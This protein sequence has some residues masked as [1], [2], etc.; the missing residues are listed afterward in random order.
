MSKWVRYQHKGQVGFGTLSDGRIEEH[1]G[2]MFAGAVATG[3]TV[4]LDEVELLTPSVPSKMVALCNNFH[5]LVTKLGMATPSEP[6]YFLK[7]NNS[8]HPHGKPIRRPAWY[9]GKVIFEG[10]LGLVIGRTCKEVAVEHALDYLFGCTCINDV[11]SIDLLNKDPSFTHWTRA[12]APDTFG[13]FGPCIATV[14][15]PSALVVKSSL[16][17]TERQ[18]YPISN[19]VFSAAQLISSI[20]HDMTLNPGD[21]VA[22]G[23]SVGVGSMKPG[24]RI[25]ISIEGIGSLINTFE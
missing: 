11:T 3:Q 8:F 20:S 10:E 17:D 22:C 13:V 18:N 2:D 12:K 7:P 1:S 25:E 9:K 15:D 24:S 19:M 21:V 4:G 23:T 5:A 6:A 14:L 16:N